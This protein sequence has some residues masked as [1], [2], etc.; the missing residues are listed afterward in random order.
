MALLIKEG[1]HLKKGPYSGR[2]NVREMA[3][4]R[5]RCD[6]SAEGVYSREGVF[7]VCIY[8]KHNLKVQTTTIITKSNKNNKN[9]H[10]I[11][12]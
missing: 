12:I 11:Y 1:P 5:E 4:V 8:F 9:L 2:A 6:Y 3:L 10:Q 7:Y